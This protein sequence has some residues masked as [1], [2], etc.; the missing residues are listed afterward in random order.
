MIRVANTIYAVE[1]PGWPV[2]RIRPRGLLGR[3]LVRLG[4]G[5][6]LKLENQEF[7]ATF[8]VKTDDEDFAIALLGPRMQA[9]ML[10]KSRV[11]WRLGHGRVC[12]VYS[13]TLKSDRIEASL[14][15]MGGFWAH[16]PRELE[17]W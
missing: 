10:T 7:N 4:G 3:L 11:R 17:D 8:Y 9:F 16:V 13:G 2:T 6:G 12:L 14:E 5:L 1:S 15:R